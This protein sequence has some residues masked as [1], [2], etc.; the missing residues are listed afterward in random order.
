MHHDPL[1]FRQLSEIT[2][3]QHGV[4][5]TGQAR[6]AGLTTKQLRRRVAEGSLERVGAHTLR[7]SFVEPSML[8]E[9]VALV[10][11]CGEGA[12]V[13]GPTAAAI[14]DLDGFTLGPPFH[15]TIPRGRL[16]ERP[17]HIL[18]TTTELPPED[19]TL[20]HGIPAFS[21]AR[22]IIDVAKFVRAGTLTA[23][24]DGALR[25]R[26]VTEDLL[27]RRI[28]Q[29]R[30]R[31]RYGIPKLFDVIE[32][33]EASRGGHSW[34]ER[35]FLQIC[36]RAGLPPPL[37]QEVI[38]DA[39]GKMVRVDFRFP[40]TRVVVEVLGYRWHRGNRQQFSRDAERINA[41]VRRGMWPI[42]FTYDHV[43]LEEAWVAAEVR[44]TLASAPV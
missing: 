16:V 43:T 27:H 38:T 44:A 42:Q 19:R 25:D 39:K 11:D 26:L 32:G 15:V 2:T 28:A 24:L 17:P 23:A 18:H 30:C 8:A 21:V 20:R 9:L 6:A 40:G 12:V 5:T 4:F 37:R 14:H 13:S 35:R 34:L 10:L 3:D 36:A 22:T 41:L 1:P 29:I 7:G 33:S 31:G